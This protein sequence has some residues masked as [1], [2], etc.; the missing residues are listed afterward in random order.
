MTLLNGIN[1]LWKDPEFLQILREE[2][3]ENRPE[4]AGDFRF[5]S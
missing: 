5:E 4:L 3:L 2:K 1:T